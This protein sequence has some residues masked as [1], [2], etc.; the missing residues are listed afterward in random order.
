MND[1]KVNQLI[2]E[3][4]HSDMQVPTDLAERL[5]Q[6]IDEAYVA[7]QVMKRRTIRCWI[8]SVSAVAASLLLVLTISMPKKSIEPA[9]VYADCIEIQDT[10]TDPTEAALAASEALK[11]LANNLN[12]GVKQMERTAQAINSTEQL[13]TKHL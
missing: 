5:E 9:M 4:L 6:R 8:Y 13:M 3:A 7:E 1:D 10:Y 12:K 11:L 2:D